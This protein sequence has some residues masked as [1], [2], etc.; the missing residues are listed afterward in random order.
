MCWNN[1]VG[2]TSCRTIESAADQN[3]VVQAGCGDTEIFIYPG[4]HF[5]IVDKFITNFHGP[6]TSRIAM[7]AAFTGKDLLLKGYAEAIQRK[8]LFYE[9]GDTTLTI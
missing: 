4:Y 8:Y 7:A 6:N 3:G 2:T 1:C 9:F 5:K